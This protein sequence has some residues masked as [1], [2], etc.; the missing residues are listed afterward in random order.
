MRIN[1]A[2]DDP[3]V[4]ARV[5]EHLRRASGVLGLRCRVAM[6]LGG[7]KAAHGVG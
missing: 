6:D 3:D 4:W 5:I 7:T 2:H 1:C